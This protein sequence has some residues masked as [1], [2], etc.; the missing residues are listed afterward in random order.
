MLIITSCDLKNIVI[1]V[2]VVV[3]VPANL[4]GNLNYNNRTVVYC[5]PLVPEHI[6]LNWAI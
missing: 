1:I 6:I 2:V 5:T 4:N 3:V